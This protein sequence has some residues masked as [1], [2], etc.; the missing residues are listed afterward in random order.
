MSRYGGTHDVSNTVALYDGCLRGVE[1]NQICSALRH[2][3]FLG[4]RYIGTCTICS[5]YETRLSLA[6]SD[7]Q[8]LRGPF[9]S[10]I[11]ELND[12]KV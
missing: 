1:V 10:L 9:D 6:L 4:V 2:R 11:A 5:K 12:S 3:L 8:L 7:R